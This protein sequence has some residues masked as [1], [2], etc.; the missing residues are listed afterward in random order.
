MDGRDDWTFY[1]K[2]I[3]FA[4]ELKKINPARLVN[5]ET[6]DEIENFFLVLGTFYNDIKSLTFHLLQTD[7]KFKERNTG[8]SPEVG[9][10]GG[11]KNHL[12]RLTAAH[13]HEF[14]KF[15]SKNKHVLK[16]E[17]FKLVHKEL[18]QDL[19]SRWDDIVDIATEKAGSKS[20][21]S[22][23]LILIRNNLAFHY[24]Q[25]GEV[26]RQGFIDYFL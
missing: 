14:F 19:K 15:L 7:N 9:E 12:N 17:E 24:F 6:N 25:G 21:F 1:M 8:I 5:Q 10:Y 16:Y 18:N 26:L 23:V 11:I 4:K 2:E 22:K 20:D 3:N 13:I